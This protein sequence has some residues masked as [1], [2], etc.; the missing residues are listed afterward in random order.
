MVDG[1]CATVHVR[2]ATLAARNAA[3]R[4]SE[5]L[6]SC[7]SFPTFALPDCTGTLWRSASG[8]ETAPKATGGQDSNPWRPRAGGGAVLLRDRAIAPQSR[9]RGLA[10]R[11]RRFAPL[12]A[13]Q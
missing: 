2:F 6:T 1:R 11:R 13:A 10:I 5:D 9:D 8:W 4:P 7:V 12:S 3:H